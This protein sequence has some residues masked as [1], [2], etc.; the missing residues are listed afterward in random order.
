MSTDEVIFDDVSLESSEGKRP[1]WF[2]DR[3]GI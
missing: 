2:G 1:G 3:T